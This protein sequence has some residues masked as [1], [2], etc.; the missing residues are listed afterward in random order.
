MTD[1]IQ[2][3]GDWTWLIY[4]NMNKSLTCTNFDYTRLNETKTDLIIEPGCWMLHNCSVV[5]ID[6]KTMV[7]EISIRSKHTY[8]SPNIQLQELAK[9]HYDTFIKKT[10]ELKWHQNIMNDNY[11]VYTRK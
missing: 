2:D 10:Q 4:T 3:M 11:R 7:T 5:E 6:N 9:Q 1:T 8:I